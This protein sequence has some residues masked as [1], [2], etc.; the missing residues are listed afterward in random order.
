[1]N[2]IVYT[3]EQLADKL[4]RAKIGI[5]QKPDTMFF[6]TLCSTL[7][8]SFTSKISTACTNG[9]KLLINPDFFTKLP[10]DE[11]V[12]L[13][14]HETMHV[15][16]MHVLRG[17]HLDPKIY[18]MAADYVI[19]LE[20]VERG[21]K[22]PKGGLLDHKY[23]GMST[24]EVYKDLIANPPPKTEMSDFESDLDQSGQQEGE[25]QEQYQ[26][27]LENIES[28]INEKVKRAIMV[29]EMAKQIGSIPND[30][31]RHYSDLKKPKV[32]W[33]QVLNR[34]VRSLS[35]DDYSW[36]RPNKRYFPNYLPK[37]HSEVLGRV[38]F[39]IDVSGSID[40][41]DFTQFISEL[42]SVMRMIKPKEIGVYQ[43]DHE[44]QGSDVVRT[45]SQLNRVKFQGGGGTNPQC[46]LDAF[47]RNQALGLI[48]LTDGY[49]HL[50]RIVDPKR[51][52]IWVVYN[53]PEFVPPFG[54]VTHFKF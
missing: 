52:V 16:Y 23:Q 47:S 48:V 51:P 30:I 13:L 38:D 49:F 10:L 50:D 46:A 6:S 41:E 7:E 39:A 26:Q 25:S 19:N 31:Q 53:N 29:A 34:F 2:A 8:T 33:K 15:A 27:R 21:F 44:L 14:A 24:D 11:Q 17:A 4:A 32:N 40:A 3:E 35:N 22:M 42:S 5:M 9:V 18:N 37:L 20:L 54:Q 45:L 43:F 12:F 36:R 1:M 28:E